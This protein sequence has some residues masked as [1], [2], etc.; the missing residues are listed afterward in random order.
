[1]R[2]RLASMSGFAV[3]LA[4]LWA[5]VVPVEGQTPASAGAKPKTP[6]AA[7]PWTLP[8]TVDG[9]PDL[10]GVWTNATPTPLE[11]PK[12]LANKA[13]F[14]QEEADNFSGADTRNQDHT[15]ADE[16]VANRRTTPAARNGGG[17][18]WQEPGKLLLRT[19]L[20]VDPPDGKIPP[21]TAEAKQR[22]NLFQEMMSKR[23]AADSYTDRNNSERC[24]SRG[25]PKLPGIYNANFQIWQSRDYVA[26]EQ[27]MIHETR[28]I[29]LTGRPH[30][31]KSVHLWLGDSVGRWE[32]DTL[33]VD[34]TNYNDKIRFNIYNCCGIAG[35]D[36]HVVERFKR[37][38]ADTI[39]YQYTVD[40]PATYTRQWTAAVPLTRSEG[41]VFEYACHEG[42]Y[43]MAAEL[44]GGRA[45][46]KAAG[47]AKR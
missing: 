21:L 30:V 6:A 42:N 16:F 36:L 12:E 37:V 38:S 31:D 39:D 23:G 41:P 28:I 17:D 7:K 44:S 43:A 22:E 26:I 4:M 19:S 8:R 32:G 15:R 18:P 35:T 24:L 9:Q 10:Q 5:A 45:Q 13:F 1:M 14:T 20:I 25:A 3:G 29:P 11:R 2:R 40:A 27:E 33:V 46:E 34:T 47:E